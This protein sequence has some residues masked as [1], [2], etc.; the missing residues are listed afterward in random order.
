[1]SC[2]PAVHTT[3]TLSAG[4]DIHINKKTTNDPSARCSQWSLACLLTTLVIE[5]S[6]CRSVLSRAILEQLQAMSYCCQKW[7]VSLDIMATKQPRH[8]HD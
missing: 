1:M 2:L 8:L 6:A 5:A 4:G 3:S 7:L